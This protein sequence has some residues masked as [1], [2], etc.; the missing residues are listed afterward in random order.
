VFSSGWPLLPAVTRDETRAPPL[1]LSGSN[2]PQ[3]L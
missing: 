3:G 2:F 1:K